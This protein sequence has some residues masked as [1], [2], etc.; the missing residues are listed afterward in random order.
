MGAIIQL[1]SDHGTKILGY[2]A[3]IIAGLPAIP[4]LIP[5]GHLKYWTAAAFIVGVLTVKRGH[6]NS[7]QIGVPNA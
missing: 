7:K 2:L 5:V 3:T 1:W 6:T 4:D